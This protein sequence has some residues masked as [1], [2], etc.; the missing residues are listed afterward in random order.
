MNTLWYQHKA[1]GGKSIISLKNKLP[2]VET[3]AMTQHMKMIV[4]FEFD[5]LSEVVIFVN[6]PRRTMNLLLCYMVA[7]S[8]DCRDAIFLNQIS[9]RTN[10]AR[11]IARALL[12]RWLFKMDKVVRH[13]RGLILL[14][15]TQG[16][17]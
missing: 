5:A 4:Q 6:F 16:Q 17:V 9:K 13:D 8:F 7:G 15:V 10:S 11:D 14:P 12:D 2:R 3:L 1:Q